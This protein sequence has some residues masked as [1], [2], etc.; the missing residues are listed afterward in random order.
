[1]G[2]ETKTVRKPLKVAQ[3]RPV[4]AREDIVAP[5]SFT[6]L[7]PYTVSIRSFHPNKQFERMGFRFHGDNRGFSLGESYF[8]GEAPPNSVTS[9]IWQTFKF[10]AGFKQTG[11]IGHLPEFELTA[12]SNPSS[13]GPGAWTVF[14]H[15]ESYESKKLKPNK[16]LE[17]LHSEVPHGAQKEIT[18]KSWYGGE[19]HAFFG[20][21]SMQKILGTTIVPTLDVT[22]ELTIRVERVQR[23][24]DIQSLVYGDGFPNTEAYIADAKGTKLFLGSHVRIGFPATHLWAD[25][26]RLMWASAIRVEIDEDGNFA[27]KLWV[28]TRVLGGPPDL[29]DEYDTTDAVEKCVPGAKP[30]VTGIFNLDPPAFTWD[31]GKAENIS[32]RSGTAPSLPMHLSAYFTVPKVRQQLPLVWEAGPLEKTTVTE[33]NASHMHRDPNAGRAADHYDVAASKWKR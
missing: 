26:K 5:I 11:D 15:T 4:D 6:K 19:N 18:L 2:G 7:A 31:C 33:W 27:D 21:V 8:G 10:D 28:F 20:S 25:G 30:K 22:S 23:Y 9:R 29:R 1:M 17:V 13:P 16:K 14:G 12:E 32:K 3:S 24:M